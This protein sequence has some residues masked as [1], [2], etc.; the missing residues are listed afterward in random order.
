MPWKN[1]ARQA[2]RRPRCGLPAPDRIPWR[3]SVRECSWGPPDN[4]LGKRSVAPPSVLPDISP[5]VGEM[6]GRTEGGA[7]GLHV[8]ALTQAIAWR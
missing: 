5:R 6:S 2:R 7:V 3:D 4:C 8:R 1:R